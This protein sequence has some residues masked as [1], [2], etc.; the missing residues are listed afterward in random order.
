MYDLLPRY[1]YNTFPQQKAI[2]K[3]KT[4]NLAFARMAM[5]FNSVTI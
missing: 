2:V 1:R 4:G 3:L 5:N